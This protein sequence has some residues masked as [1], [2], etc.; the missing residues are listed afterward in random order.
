LNKFGVTL[1]M[2]SMTFVPEIEAAIEQLPPHKV[3]AL[4]QWLEEYQQMIKRLAR[5][6]LCK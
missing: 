1:I 5:S 6:T 2:S 3:K 4:A